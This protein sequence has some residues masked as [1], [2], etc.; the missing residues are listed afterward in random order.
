MPR[1]YRPSP[2]L[3]ISLVALFVSLGGAAYAVSIPANSVGPAQLKTNAVVSTKLA[4][5]SVTDRAIR[6][7]AVT[8]ADIENGAIT[9][10][11]LATGS[12]NSAKLA[13]NAVQVTDLG[14]S[15][16]GTRALAPKS[17]NASKLNL[18]FT[19]VVKYS[20]T[21]PSGQAAFRDVRAQCPS[22]FRI[23]SGGG[24]WVGPNGTA[25]IQT[26]SAL[27]GSRPYPPS[28]SGSQQNAW[29]VWGRDQ[30]SGAR[31]LMVMALCMPKS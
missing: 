6:A 5:D 29:E 15:V 23:V 10:A 12:V 28:S 14:T 2:A 11:K 4:T 30:S 24:G 8:N 21:V 22:N 18:P 26:E 20:S 27:S 13:T 17:V 19:S 9:N 7:G 3:A 25:P 1:K 16:V 31:R